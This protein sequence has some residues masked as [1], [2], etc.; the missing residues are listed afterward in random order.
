MSLANQYLASFVKLLEE[1]Q[2][3]RSTDHAMRDL[4]EELDILWYKLTETEITY[5]NSLLSSLLSKYLRKKLTLQQLK[6][7]VTNSI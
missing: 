4:E 2:L 3:Q 6:R 7:L 5:V 1:T